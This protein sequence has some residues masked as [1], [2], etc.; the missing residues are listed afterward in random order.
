MTAFDMRSKRLPNR[1]VIT[2]EWSAVDVFQPAK[3]RIWSTLS[4]A[5]GLSDFGVLRR[6]KSLM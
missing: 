4:F 5:F 3:L 2:N 6:Y 1:S